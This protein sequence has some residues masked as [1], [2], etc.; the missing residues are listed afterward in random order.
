MVIKGLTV[1]PVRFDD[2]K[3][4]VHYM[5]LKQHEVRRSDE[6]KPKERTVFIGNIP[7]WATEES[8]KQVFQCCG[9]V[10]KVFFQ[11]R[12]SPGLE[13]D[14]NEIQGFMIP[15]MNHQVA[16]V[17]FTKKESVEKALHLPYSSPL[18]LSTK[19]VPITHGLA[20]YKAF[21][22]ESRT[23][24][25]S[26]DKIIV[27]IREYDRKE[28]EKEEAL[29]NSGP[30][31]EGWVTVTRVGKNKGAP[32]TQ[33]EQERVL[34]RKRKKK[35]ELSNFYAFQIRDEKKQKIDDLKAQ[36]DKDKS[37]VEQ[38]RAQRKFKPY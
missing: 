37:K 8:L 26:K 31:E 7:V 17:V 23:K 22:L 32:R 29:K 4:A 18:V 28:K 1:V 15:K 21:Y 25:I 19:Q 6:E 27:A 35:Q 16:Y 9:R 20:E 3:P 10:E 2:T 12:A 36:F 33:Q 34:T 5:Y 14:N 30:D 24:K 11:R 38:M 13:T